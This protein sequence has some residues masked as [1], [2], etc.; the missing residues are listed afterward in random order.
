[1]SSNPVPKNKLAVL[2]THRN[3]AGAFLRDEVLVVDKM[4]AIVLKFKY[5][6]DVYDLSELLED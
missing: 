2:L 1:M 6:E 4:D 3:S 5:G